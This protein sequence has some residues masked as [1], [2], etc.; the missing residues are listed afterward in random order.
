M[1]HSSFNNLYIAYFL[2]NDVAVVKRYA[3]RFL[4][5]KKKTSYIL[6]SD[7]MHAFILG[8]AAFWISREDEQQES[9]KWLDIGWRFT[10]DMK[11]WAEQGSEWNFQQKYSLLRAE[12]YY[13]SGNLEAA[14]A[15]YNSAI[16]FAR[17]H[18][19]INDEAL[20]CELAAKFYFNAGDK[21]TSLTYFQLAHAKY[22]AWGSVKKASQLY[23]ETMQ[24]F[25]D[26]VSLRNSDEPHT[27]INTNAH[28]RREI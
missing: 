7:T 26:V 2:S 17:T 9:S 3:Q 12:G 22:G 16:T 19:A 6:F 5:H 8:L 27:P 13:S 25:S 14:K 28:K 21:E 10:G 23:E 1:Q 4:E 11:L 24:S 15:A 20:A 18:K